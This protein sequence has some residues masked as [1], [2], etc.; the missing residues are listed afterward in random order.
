MTFPVAFRTAIYGLCFGLMSRN[1]PTTGPGHG[2]QSLSN[3]AHCT[4]SQ[5]CMPRAS[6]PSKC[7]QNGSVVS[8]F[9]SCRCPPLLCS[10]SPATYRPSTHLSDGPPLLSCRRTARLREVEKL[11]AA[12]NAWCGSSCCPL[13]L[14]FFVIVASVLRLRHPVFSCRKPKCSRTASGP[15]QENQPLECCAAFVFPCQQRP[16]AKHPH[17]RRCRL[18]L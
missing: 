4:W 12:S 10:F 18:Q 17:A 9:A 11:R 1:P 16:C 3:S 7:L 13:T 6:I 14:L 8:P 2:P 5:I 15:G